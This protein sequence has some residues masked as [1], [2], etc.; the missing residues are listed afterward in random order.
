MVQGSSKRRSWWY[1]PG[2]RYL[3]P[4]EW[5]VDGRGRERVQGRRWSSS[6]CTSKNNF[7]FLWSPD[8][9]TLSSIVKRGT[10]WHCVSNV[11]MTS[12]WGEIVRYYRVHQQTGDGGRLDDAL[13]Q[14]TLVASNSYALWR[15]I[16]RT[17]KAW[18][19]SNYTVECESV[20]DECVYVAVES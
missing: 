6:K 10:E 1:R 5:V 17:L 2:D 12:L 14:C 9:K 4:A 11:T 16:M 19:G 8:N 18:N 20:C 3:C 13:L 15:A 7:R